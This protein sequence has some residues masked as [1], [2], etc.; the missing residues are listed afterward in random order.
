[1]PR[2]ATTDPVARFGQTADPGSLFSTNHQPPTTNFKPLPTSTAVSASVSEIR[3]G[4]I[5]DQITRCGPLTL[6]ELCEK[7]GTQ[8]NQISGRITDLIK[9]NILI[10]TG[11]LR[12]HPL[13]GVG[14]RVYELVKDVA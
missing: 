7:L 11:Q 3:R 5:L 10:P 4:Q 6:F 8:P 2:M 13:S 9:E 14:C 1:M 12:K